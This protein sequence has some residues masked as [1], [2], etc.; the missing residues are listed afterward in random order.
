MKD[1]PGAAV[2]WLVR[3]VWGRG[4]APEASRACLKAAFELWQVPEVMAVIF[5][6]NSKSARVLEKL[7]FKPNGMLNIYDMELE[8]FALQSSAPWATASG[9]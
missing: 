1:I 5:P 9:T 2:G 8:C 4:I 7:A 6:G 3:R